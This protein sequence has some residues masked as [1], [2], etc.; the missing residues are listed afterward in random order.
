MATIDAVVECLPWTG[1]VSPWPIVE[2][3]DKFIRLYAATSFENV[4]RVMLQL[5]MS[6]GVESF[7]SADAVLKAIMAEPTWILPGGL[8]AQD[9]TGSTI[10]PSCCCG[11]EDW[12]EWL[13]FL[14]NGQ[15]PFLGHDPSQGIERSG[16]RIRVV[17]FP[18]HGSEYYIEFDPDDFTEQLRQVQDDLKQFLVVLKNW[19]LLRFD[20]APGEDFVARFDEMFEINRAGSKPVI[21]TVIE[22]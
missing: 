15:S 4:G 10:A 3:T 7:L 14:N 8:R 11:L 18:S 20:F 12:R 22:T 19:T 16:N 21:K 9:V 1:D 13:D 5:A 17:S 2:S 6:C